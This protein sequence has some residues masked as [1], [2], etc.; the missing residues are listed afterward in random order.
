[1]R[2]VGGSRP[3]SPRVRGTAPWRDAAYVAL[4]FETT[5]LNYT[6]D[7]VISYGVVPIESGRILVGESHHELV[8]P[9]KAPS[10]RSQTIHLLR[11]TDLADAPPMA[12]A[13]APLRAAL[14]GR[15]L[16]AWFAEVEVA[17]LRGIFGG[18]ERW[19]RRRVIDVR[20]L[21][22]AVDEAPVKVRAERGYG[23]SQTAERY[24]VPV[25]SPHDA[26]DDALVTAQLFLVLARKV[27]ESPEPTLADLRRLSS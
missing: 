6:T 14:D 19:W 1:V 2:P 12:T 4:D 27:P 5:G 15:V 25:A 11:P 18:S 16:L 22:I 21:A 10:P 17:F 26:L 3:R 23:L 24:G 8:R 13:A 20:D 7:H 9:P